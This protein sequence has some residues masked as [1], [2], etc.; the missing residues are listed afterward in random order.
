MNHDEG[1]WDVA[2]HFCFDILLVAAGALSL[3]LADLFVESYIS[4]DLNRPGLS[5]DM[6]GALVRFR[7]LNLL[8]GTLGEDIDLAGMPEFQA[9]VAE[10]TEELSHKKKTPL[11][12]ALDNTNVNDLCKS[13]IE[14]RVKKPQGDNPLLNI[15]SNFQNTVALMW[16]REPSLDR[17]VLSM[18]LL[19]GFFA[20]LRFLWPLYP[21]EYYHLVFWIAG[22]CIATAGFGSLLAVPMIWVLTLGAKYV[23]GVYV[24]STCKAVLHITPEELLESL[25]KAAR[26]RSS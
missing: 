12:S 2:K 10:K 6:S 13:E 15:V 24:A 7:P 11:E 5:A 26:L 17:L 23:A 9:C 19:L 21:R 4:G 1:L 14:A 25:R 20:A 22:M 3:G 18:Q 16:G 8:L